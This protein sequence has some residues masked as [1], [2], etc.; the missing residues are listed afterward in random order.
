MCKDAVKKLPFVIG[1]VPGQYKTKEMCQK[2]ILENIGIVESV[3]DWYKN[4]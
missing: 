3:S 4:N 1:H 2:A